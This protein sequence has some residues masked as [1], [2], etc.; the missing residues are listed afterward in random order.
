M[1]DTDISKSIIILLV[2]LTVVVSILGTWVIL[3]EIS[4]L[5]TAPVTAQ[6]GT[7]SGR[8]NIKIIEPGVPTSSSTGK[9]TFTVING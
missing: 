6:D 4:Q 8:V 5:Q 1:E 3:E 7:A 2:I 9:V